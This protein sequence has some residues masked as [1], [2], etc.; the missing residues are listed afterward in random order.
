MSNPQGVAIQLTVFLEH[1]TATAVRDDDGWGAAVRVGKVW[2]CCVFLGFLVVSSSDL[3][4][5]S[6]YSVTNLD[7]RVEP[8]QDIRG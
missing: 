3:I 4:R 5:G 2:W 8:G 1:H 6:N 7:A